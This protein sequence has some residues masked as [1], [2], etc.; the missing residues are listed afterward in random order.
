MGQLYGV[1]PTEVLQLLK[2]RMNSGYRPGVD[3]DGNRI[4]LI[5]EGGGM[6]GVISCAYLDAMYQLGYGNC[7]DAIYGNSAGAINSAYFIAGNISI[8]HSIY[9]ENLIGKLFIRVSKWPEIMNIH[10]L[11]NKWITTGKPVSGEFVV[12]SKIDFYISATDIDN[13]CGLYF[14]NHDLTAE[15]VMLAIKASAS[16]PLFT[17]NC[18]I[19]NSIK[20]NDGMMYGAIPYNKAIED[21]CTHIVSALTAQVGF[22]KNPKFWKLCIEKM[23]L[24]PFYSE[25]YVQEYNKRDRCYNDALDHIFTTS[26]IPSLAIAPTHRAN[27]ISNGE[28][29]QKKLI[30]IVYTSF[31]TVA[32]LFEE[33]YSQIKLYRTPDCQ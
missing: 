5:V 15:Q 16:A 21:N 22:R 27:V 18:E 13:V 17:T 32:D 20:C 31:R 19:V 26:K 4:G 7:F 29:N 24:M 3:D 23:M 10:Y 12:A 8:G 14:Y 11:F 9:Y 2:K 25:K 30:D 6:R 1:F 33:D 28:T